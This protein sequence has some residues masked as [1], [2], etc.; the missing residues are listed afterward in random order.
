MPRRYP[1]NVY[2]YSLAKYETSQVFPPQNNEQTV[3]GSLSWQS[4]RFQHQS[5]AV[6]IPSFASLKEHLFTVNC[7]KKTKIQKKAGMVYFKQFRG[8]NLIIGFHWQEH[9]S[10]DPREKD[11]K[12]FEPTTYTNDNKLMSSLATSKNLFCTNKV[13]IY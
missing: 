5:P 12:I 10:F 9:H 3:Q 11:R 8:R 7:F 13:F 1:H 6:R 2:L 4:S